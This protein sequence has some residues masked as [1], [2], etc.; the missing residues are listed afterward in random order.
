MNTIVTRMDANDE[1]FKRILDDRDFRARARLLRGE[2]Y[3]RL[4]A[5]ADQLG[6]R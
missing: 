3:E 2:V 1:I 6:G 4:R 5:N